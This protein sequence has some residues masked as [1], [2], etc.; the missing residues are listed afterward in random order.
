MTLNNLRQKITTKAAKIGVVGLGYVGL[1][2]ACKFAEVGF[3]VSGVDIAV[4]K[5]DLVNA[6]LL[7]IHDKE[8]D[9]AELLQ[10]VVAD[11]RLRAYTSAD[12]LNEAEVVIIAVETPVEA[13]SKRPAYL[14]LRS[15]VA[16]VGKVM[17][18]GTLIIIESTVAP[19]TTARMVRPLLEEVS[20]L[21]VNEDFFLGHCPERVMP[22][23]LL[24]NLTAMSRV[25]GGGTPE[26]AGVMVALYETS[27]RQIWITPTGSRLKW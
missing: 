3:A 1:T 23:H 14:A 24:G 19:G 2:V 7:P 11:K 20:G 4:E 25:C 15:A 10:Q 9:M 16:A 22:G 8:P 27:S 12:V 5:V 17:Q 6:G 26:T 18:R 13:G 21:H